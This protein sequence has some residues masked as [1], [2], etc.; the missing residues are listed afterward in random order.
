M[1]MRQAREGGPRLGGERNLEKFGERF[2]AAEKITAA[3]VCGTRSAGEELGE[4]AYA[5][6][7]ARQ[8]GQPDLEPSGIGGGPFALPASPVGASL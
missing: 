6:T 3:V 7:K 2:S 5:A 8:T 4:T 1:R